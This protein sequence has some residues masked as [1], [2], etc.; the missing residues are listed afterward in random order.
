[1][2]DIPFPKLLNRVLNGIQGRA[3]METREAIAEA[4]EL[5]GVGGNCVID[6]KGRKF[7]SPEPKPDNGKRFVKPCWWEREEWQPER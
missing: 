1:M 2:T 4:A 6:L 5:L 7:V 3:D